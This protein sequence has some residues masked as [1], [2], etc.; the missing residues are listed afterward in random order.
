MIYEFMGEIVTEK[1][2]ENAISDELEMATFNA[3]ALACYILAH[4]E[5][6]NSFDGLGQGAI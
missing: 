4:D 6:V 3:F 5:D 2:L 1:A